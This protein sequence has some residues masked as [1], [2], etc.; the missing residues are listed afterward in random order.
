[1]G[2][3]KRRRRDR[4]DEPQVEAFKAD[5][6]E[7]GAFICTFTFRLPFRMGISDD[8]DQ[9]ITWPAEYAK[10]EDAETFAKSPF[11]RLRLFN[12]TLPD[13]RFSPANAPAAVRHFYQAEYDVGPADDQV[14]PYLYEQ[15]VSL[16]TP[17]ALLTDEDPAD[18][19]YAFHRC[20]SALNV[21]LQA[22][23]LARNDDQVQPISSRELRPIV[24]A[25]SMS[26]TGTWT[27]RGPILM[28]PDGKARPLRSRPVSEHTESLNRAMQTMLFGNPFVRSWQWKARAARRR[29]EGDNADAIVS[30]QIAAEVFLFEIWGLIL[31]DEGRTPSEIA[32]LRRIT[33][34]ASLVKTELSQRLGGSWDT[35]RPRTR[36]GQYWRHLYVLRTRVVHAGYL[37]H[38]GDA[39]RAERAFKGLEGFVRERLERQARRYPTTVEALQQLAEVTGS[40]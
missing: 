17:A 18:G 35:T 30:F 21:Y 13:R 27:E 29:Y 39:E 6:A 14:D 4:T 33:S 15:W 22:F 9:E 8:F 28:H 2:R 20:L 26:L 36:L 23:A 3:R 25:G 10:D 31:A 38:D 37:P 5:P 16:E 32:E 34:F 12:A 40:S 1:M 19:G 11:V 7:T 24:I